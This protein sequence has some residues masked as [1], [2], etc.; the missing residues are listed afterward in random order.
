MIER[1]MIGSRADVERH[2][3]DIIGR[4]PGQ[5]HLRE[6]VVRQFADHLIDHVSEQIGS[7]FESRLNWAKWI[8]ECWPGENDFWDDLDRVCMELNDEQN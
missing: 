4:L 7:P 5:E 1:V 2:I 8:D 6:R 3:D